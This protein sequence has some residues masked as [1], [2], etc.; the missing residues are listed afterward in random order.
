[1]LTL[2][3]F[4]ANMKRLINLHKDSILKFTNLDWESIQKVTYLY[5]F[6]RE[7]Q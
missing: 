7:V 1:M 3:V 2:D 6:D 4:P 5:E